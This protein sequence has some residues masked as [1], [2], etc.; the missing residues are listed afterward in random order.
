MLVLGSRPE[1]IKKAPLVKAEA[2]IPMEP[3]NADDLICTLLKFKTIPHF[4]K[5]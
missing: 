2:G 1:A 3:E 5:N 4:V